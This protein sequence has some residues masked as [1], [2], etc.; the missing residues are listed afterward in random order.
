MRLNQTLTP[1]LKKCGQALFVCLLILPSLTANNLLNQGENVNKESFTFQKMELLKASVLRQWKK[2]FHYSSPFTTTQ[3]DS[4][5]WVVPEICNNGIDDD[6]DG[7]I[8]NADPDCGCSETIMLVARDNANILRVN[9]TNGGTTT[10]ATTSPYTTGNLNAMCANPDRG[11]VYYCRDKMVYYWNPSTNVH[12][13]VANLA[14]QIGS[15]E[16]LSS[17][18]GGYYNGYMYLGT[19]NGNPGTFPKVY[20]LLLSADGLTAAANAVDLG[21]P[22]PTN[23]SWGDLIVTRE[24][25]QTI[26]YGMTSTGNSYYWKYN[27]ATST[28]ILIKNNLPKEMQIGVDINGDTWA[29]TLSSGTIQKINRTTGVFY[30]S[31]YNI[32]GKIW[33]LSGPINC[34]Q[35]LEICYNGIDDDGDGLAD[36][37]DPDCYPCVQCDTRVSNG[38]VALYEFK[39]GEGSTVYDVS[40]YGTQLNLLVQNPA[41][42]S[43]NN[44]CGLAINAATRIESAGPA[45]KITNAVKAS[46]ALTI[47]TWVKAANN[48]QTGPA[49]IVSLSANANNRNVTLSQNA[50]KYEIRM[51]AASSSLNG[52][53][54]KLT[55]AG[56]FNHNHYQHIVYT[57]D[58]SNGN[59]NLYVDGMVAY[60]GIRNG[61]AA[62]WDSNYKLL[63]ANELVDS[64]PWLGEISYLAFYDQVFSSSDVMNNLDQGPCCGGGGTKPDF[65]CF[66][67]RDVELN[68]TGINNS[69]PKTL[70]IA[71]PSNIDSVVVEVVYKGGDPGPSISVQSAA[72]T[73]YT[74]NKQTVGSNAAVY[75][76]VLPATSSVTYSNTTNMSFA[77]SLSAFVFRNGQPGKTVVTKFTT[78]GGYNG[79]FTLPYG[80]PVGTEPRNVRILL[81]VSELTYDNRKLN[82]Y[83]FAGSVSTSFTKTWGP[84]GENFPNGCCIDTVEFMLENVAPNVTQVVIE[85]NSPGGSGQSFV[86][87]GTVGVE[88]FCDEICG[89]GIDDDGDGYTDDEDQDCLCPVI[90]ATGSTA[91]NICEGE[92]ATFNVTTNAPD[93][94][95][96]YIEFY[97][98]ETPQLNPYTSGDPK[99]WLG[100]FPN[101]TGTGSISTAN[102][103]VNTGDTKIYYVYGCVKPEPQDP[104]TCYPLVEYVLNVKRSP[105]PNAG[106]DVTICS[107]ATTTLT[108]SASGGQAP[109]TFN[110][111]HGLGSGA[112]KS[113]SPESTTTYTVTVTGGTGCSIT[114]NVTVTVIPSPIASAGSN[115]AIC[116]GQSATLTATATGGVEPYTFSWNANLGGGA[117]K[118]VSPATTKTYT[119]TVS[120]GNGCASDSQVT[121]MVN[122]CVENCVNGIDD[123]GDG[124]IDCADPDCGFSVSLGSDL[125][126]CNGSS[127]SVTASVSGGGSYTYSWSHGLGAG[128]FK[129]LSPPST[130]TYSVTATAVTGCTGTGQV[131][132]TVNPCPEDCTNG[133]DDDG[134]GLVDCD[135][136]DCSATGAPVLADDFFTTCPGLPF[137]ELVNSNDA[138]LQ[139]PA[140]SIYLPPTSGSVSIDGLGKFVYTPYGPDCTTDV[141]IYQVCNQTT[142]CCN[143]AAV[144]ITLGDTVAPVLT[145]IP[146][147]LT[148]GCDDQVPSPSQVLAQDACP[149]IFINF[150]EA[151][152]DYSAG[153][154]ASYTITRTWTTHDLCGNSSSGQQVI[155]V[156]DLV[157]PE[158][159]RVYTLKNGKRLVAGM[160]KRTTGDWKYVPFPITFASK[161]VVFSQVISEVENAAVVMQQRNISTQGFE[162]RL[163]EQE[164]SNG[165]HLP[166]KVVWLAVEQGVQGG[167][168][169]M[170]VGT[171]SALNSSMVQLNFG[172]IFSTIPGFIAAT[173]TVNEI[174][175][176]TPRYQEATTAGLKIFLDEESSNDIE[177][178]HLNESLGYMAVAPDVELTDTLGDFLGETGTLNLTNAWTTVALSR[179]YSK[180]VVIFGGTSNNDTDPVTIRVRNV[181]ENS[182]EVRLQE[183]NYQDGT[184]GT[185]SVSYVVV[186]GSVPAKAGYYCDGKPDN[187]KV[188]VNIFAIDNCDGQLSFNFTQAEEMLENGLQTMRT[189]MAIDDCGNVQ[190]VSRTDT[191]TVAAMRLKAILYGAALGNGGGSLMRDDLRLNGLIPSTEPYQ[192]MQSFVH[193]GKSGGEALDPD[194]LNVSGNHAIVDWV[195]VE[196]RDSLDRTKVAA[197]TSV[198]LRRDGSVVTASG[199]SVIYF[200]AL[201]EGKYFVSIRHRNHLG[202]ATE[203]AVYLSSI[204]PPLIDFTDL[205]LAVSGSV[206][207]GRLVSGKRAMWAGDYSADRRVVYQGPS[208]DIFYL[209]S[210]VLADPENTSNLANFISTGYDL[211]DFNLD[212]RIIYQ[213]PNNERANLLYHTVLA[214][215]GNFSFLSNF[216]VSEQLP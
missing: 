193:K 70:N 18:G 113:V 172:Q 174:D 37:D 159:F 61:S 164:S 186:E 103:P 121:V 3:Q 56:A 105:V 129:T 192:A 79:T 1:T 145:N 190:L 81:P 153:G 116:N 102:F 117:V 44:G 83:A 22:I 140:Y 173:Q 21:I 87:A 133:I 30:G 215:P 51:R 17:G 39:E 107:G 86:V 25:G 20:R 16:S 99:V 196:I 74:A 115:V 199:D 92:T 194:L 125:T 33:D 8:D 122:S 50:E 195:F 6:G 7:L 42:T 57:W 63:L 67:G 34:P 19:E 65:G 178:G 69:I 40:G 184:H 166:E 58:G 77:Q 214:H 91:L 210:R 120:S 43:W 101:T 205:A 59:E 2:K 48:T 97:R 60:S 144:M 124:L 78:V 162:M 170:K 204:A 38:L 146:A 163:S 148:I 119:V 139:S 156:Q 169:E 182:F 138:N 179:Q 154:C 151:V 149:G 32:G 98:F 175:P 62:Y 202:M 95:Y 136:P 47:E 27:I 9:L 54:A 12:G 109:F 211:N 200:P 158:L 177:T 134:D 84:A 31:S 13:I 28:Y 14:G 126:I 155:T 68:F 201:H 110:W 212:G 143:Q 142:G 64:R 35:A 26:I 93:P 127:I 53:T 11:L 10:V 180:P 141:F 207:A 137:T 197:T 76:T 89:N 213:G 66:D 72:G 152:D 75:R 187:L 73:N 88:I 5:E 41:N 82:F 161:P 167:A 80:I 208:N 132:V 108:A 45:T 96:T 185:E 15:S 111:S 24:N 160:A 206:E 181:T 112:T 209:F 118:T 29:G 130:T 188:G 216:I 198:L 157:A 135:D 90:T 176:V 191:C 52:E 114:D 100:E 171:M 94:P 128:A 46:N 106:P 168:N 150:E 165:L 183:W 4:F 189:W 23:T 71:N 123:D 147:D 104:S 85:I 203:K 49:R 36:C 131:T 55:A